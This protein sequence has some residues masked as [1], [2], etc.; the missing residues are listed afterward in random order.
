[1]HRKS[2]GS[3]HLCP[4]T[5]KNTSADA[6]GRLLYP[7]ITFGP[8]TQTSPSCTAADR[9]S[10]RLQTCGV[11]RFV[12]FICG[13]EF[14]RDDMGGFELARWLRTSYCT[15]RPS[16]RVVLLQK[17]RKRQNDF[18]ED[19]VSVYENM[20]THPL[21]RDEIFIPRWLQVLF[22]TTAGTP[23]PQHLPARGQLQV[24]RAF[25]H[26][27][28]GQQLGCHQSIIGTST[29]QL[30]QRSGVFQ[31]LNNSC[32]SPSTSVKNAP[33]PAASPLPP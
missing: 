14:S 15:R 31:F 33:L 8:L 20:Q 16:Q 19:M 9:R 32:A 29:K 6:S 10:K 18:R 17:T 5:S 21:R 7:C 24:G 2:R 3:A 30:Q 13:S 1:M 23:E 12:T 28:N 4:S 26:F 11:G 22:P 25:T 27:L